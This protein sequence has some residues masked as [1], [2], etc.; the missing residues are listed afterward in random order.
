M[1][2]IGF[3]PFG[4]IAQELKE[5][6]GFLAQG[7]WGLEPMLPKEELGNVDLVD[8]TAAALRLPV[9][10]PKRINPFGFSANDFQDWEVT[11]PDSTR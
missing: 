5:G 1:M 6:L 4:G 7:V 2:E 8:K 9:V 10:K 3:D 11:A